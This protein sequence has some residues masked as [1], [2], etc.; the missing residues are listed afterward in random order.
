MIFSLSGGR[1]ESPHWWNS[2]RLPLCNWFH[3]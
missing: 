1:L 3:L 2:S